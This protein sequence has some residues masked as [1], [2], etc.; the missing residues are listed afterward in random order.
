MPASPQNSSPKQVP[1][2][3][4]FAAS[5]LRAGGDV[6]LHVHTD[7]GTFELALPVALA[8]GIEL[9]VPPTAA[10]AEHQVQYAARRRKRG[11]GRSVKPRDLALYQAIARE[12]ALDPDLKAATACARHGVREK[13]FSNWKMRERARAAAA[14]SAPITKPSGRL[15]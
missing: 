12:L 9:K 7:A 11:S 10:T 5:V 14:R 1:S 3:R 15:L 8:L 13:T 6:R 2:I 4:V